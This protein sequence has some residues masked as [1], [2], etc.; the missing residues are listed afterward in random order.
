M[1]R[2]IARMQHWLAGHRGEDLADVTATFFPDVAPDLLASSLAR[3]REAGIWSRSPEISPQGFA[4]LADSLVSGGFISRPPVLSGLRRGEPVGL[5]RSF[6]TIARLRARPESE[7]AGTCSR[8]G[9]QVPQLIAMAPLMFSTAASIRPR[10]WARS[11]PVLQRAVTSRAFTTS[12]K[13]RR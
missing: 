6:D 8:P 2:A 1:T 5:C 11:V 3:Y 12:K 9:A 4:R 13:S 7:R 10:S